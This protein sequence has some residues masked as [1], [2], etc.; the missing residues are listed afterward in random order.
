MAAR[1]KVRQGHG[2]P[3][4]VPARLPGPLNQLGTCPR[5]HSGGT[6]A[7][8]PNPRR[9]WAM[10]CRSRAS[11]NSGR[12]FTVFGAARCDWCRSDDAFQLLNAVIYLKRAFDECDVGKVLRFH[13][14]ERFKI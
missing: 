9:R 14:T 6:P 11:G 2:P 3:A 5:P 12:D 4:D 1:P 10:I 13:A 7:H 8:T